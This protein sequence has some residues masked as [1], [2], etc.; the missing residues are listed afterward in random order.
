MTYERS[1]VDAALAR[2]LDQAIDKILDDPAAAKSFPVQIGIAMIRTV[3]RA[4]R[5]E[6][7]QPAPVRK[8][9][10]AV[11]RRGFELVQESGRPP[12]EAIES[13]FLNREPEPD[14]AC[15]ARQPDEP[16]GAA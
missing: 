2:R 6:G 13:Q 14:P 12:D 9:S 7:Q 10:L 8:L 5:G 3:E 15:L 1:A 11:A 4:L 16:E